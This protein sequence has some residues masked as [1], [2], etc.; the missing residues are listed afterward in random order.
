LHD[1]ICQALPENGRLLDLGCGINSDLESY[2]T[3]VRE[4]WGTDFQSHPRL[5]HREWFRLLRPDGAI[6]FPDDHFDLVAAIMVLEHVADPRAFLR[7]VAR[8]LR[9]GGRFVG[10]TISGSHYVAA[11]RRLFG[12]LPHR[13]SQ[14]LTKRLYGRAEE[15]TFPAFYRLNTARR[16]RR[17]C[18]AA[19]L[20]LVNVR[21]YADP[22]YFR[23]ARSLEA[24]AVLTDRALD[25]ICPGWGRLYMTVTIE[26]P[27]V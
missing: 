17:F 26:K 13:V 16:L 18:G 9:P 25:G 11:I 12:L 27:R 23:F 20:R 5:R 6:P 3:P 8:V 2:R 21:R 19:G 15:D 7:E 14:A 10:H 4:V 22:G 24:L 1:T